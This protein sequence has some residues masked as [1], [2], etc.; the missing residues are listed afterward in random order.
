MVRSD[1]PS[2]ETERRDCGSNGPRLTPGGTS[3]S[4]DVSDFGTRLGCAVLTTLLKTQSEV[5]AKCRHLS[6]IFRDNRLSDDFTFACRRFPPHIR[7]Q[8][9]TLGF[10]FSRDLFILTLAH[11]VRS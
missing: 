1:S 10:S 4:I 3:T 9:K 5:L 8:Q 11:H 6:A 7:F 2:K